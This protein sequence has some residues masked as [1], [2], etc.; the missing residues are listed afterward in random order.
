MYREILRWLRR[1]CCLSG[2]DRAAML[3]AME[4]LSHGPLLPL[5]SANAA[6][7]LIKHV[8]QRSAQE[9]VEHLCAAAKATVA[10]SKEVAAAA[11]T[12]ADTFGLMA[13][14]AASKMHALSAQVQAS[15]LEADLQKEVDNMLVN[16]ER[17]AH[18]LFKRGCRCWTSRIYGLFCGSVVYDPKGPLPGSYILKHLP[19]ELQ[20]GAE[21]IKKEVMDLVTDAC[22]AADGAHDFAAAAISMHDLLEVD[23]A[24]IG[25][26]LEVQQVQLENISLWNAWSLLSGIGIALEKIRAVLPKCGAAA[27]LRETIKQKI[28]P[29]EGIVPDAVHHV[30]QASDTVLARASTM[31]SLC[32]LLEATKL[33]VSCTADCAGA[34]EAALQAAIEGNTGVFQAEDGPIQVA[35][36]AAAEARKACKK[37]DA[38]H[39]VASKLL[40]NQLL[41][42]CAAAGGASKA[43]AGGVELV[44]EL[45]SA[46]GALAAIKTATAARLKDVEGALD[47]VKQPTQGL[48][49]ILDEAHDLGR[50]L[51]EAVEV[52]QRLVP[53][54]LLQPQSWPPTLPAPVAQQPRGPPQAVAESAGDV[55]G[56]ADPSLVSHLQAP[57]L[58]QDCS[59]LAAQEQGLADTRGRSDGRA[60]VSHGSI[61]GQASSPTTVAV[62]AASSSA[63]MLHGAAQGTLDEEPVT[64]RDDQA[65]HLCGAF[66]KQQLRATYAY[67]GAQAVVSAAAAC[68]TAQVAEDHAQDALNAE[69]NVFHAAIRADKKAAAEFCKVCLD[70]ADKAA[71][72]AAQADTQDQHTD[73]WAAVAEQL[74]AEL[75]ALAEPLSLP[76]S[77]LKKIRA[78][79][80]AQDAARRAAPRPRIARLL[81]LAADCT[82]SA[83][84]EMHQARQLRC[85]RRQQ[86][87]GA[88]QEARTRAMVR[89]S[90]FHAC[91]VLGQNCGSHRPWLKAYITQ[92]R[93]CA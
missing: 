50:P 83:Q 39:A 7:D 13:G 47:A 3:T 59:K 42:W 64:L 14:G 16:L 90:S 32:Q 26:L 43:A 33:V 66:R 77:A 5:F 63:V 23:G 1:M 79:G 38:A 89:R 68:E 49:K 67:C 20:Q 88:G 86:A 34:V 56:S 10:G 25:A 17:S 81:V 70:A 69:R 35:N 85:Q 60:G 36:H 18:G 58:H 44:R 93:A 48:G 30:M 72:A 52:L 91:I 75:V 31:E 65:L 46:A 29:W 53:D 74:A 92:A 24:V 41:K 8:T 80:K 84:A 71:D 82:A 22:T 6:S 19:K 45:Q 61:V 57:V 9:A 12:A 40:P 15:A 21:G 62:S 11:A 37:A 73:K 51:Q 76:A 2:H 55:H 87:D 78:A 28:S 54:G 27:G 4:E